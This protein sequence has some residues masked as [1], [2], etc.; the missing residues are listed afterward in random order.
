MS[1]EKERNLLNHSWNCVLPEYFNKC[2]KLTLNQGSGICVFRVHAS[3]GN[4]GNN[5]EFFF[6]SNQSPQWKTFLKDVPNQD[7][8]EN[9]YDPS[10]HIL[11]SVHVPT[12]DDNEEL[13]DNRTVGEIRMFYNDLDE[14]KNVIEVN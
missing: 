12:I 2:K 6:I 10:K 7:Y 3:P 14:D 11:V 9:N 13:N 1:K 5:C 4:D 8:I